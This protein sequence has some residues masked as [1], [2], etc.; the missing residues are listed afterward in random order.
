MPPE[1]G[2][3]AYRE[4]RAECK[5][6]DDDRRPNHANF[7]LYL[8]K[9]N[10]IH[11][12]ICGRNGASGHTLNPAFRANSATLDANVLRSYCASSFSCARALR[13]SATIGSSSLSVIFHLQCIFRRKNLRS[14]ALRHQR[15]HQHYTISPPNP[16]TGYFQN[17]T[18]PRVITLRCRGLRTCSR[19]GARASRR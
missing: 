18:K 1:I 4:D 10:A 9:L 16:Q 7:S 19:R 15:K 6:R 14:G 13:T 12:A 11:Y 17:A 8:A 3:A 5:H 2:S